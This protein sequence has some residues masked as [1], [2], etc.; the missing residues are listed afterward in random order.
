ME[1]IKKVAKFL[2]IETKDLHNFYKISAIKTFQNDE[3]IF[4][5][6]EKAKSLMFL[7][8]GYMGAYHID[9]NYKSTFF[10][11]FKADKFVGEAFALR[12]TTYP[13]NI[14]SFGTSKAVFIDYKKFKNLFFT[15]NAVLQ[16]II[17]SI[18]FKLDNYFQFANREKHNSI[19]GK[20]CLF[21]FKYEEL[22]GLIKNKETAFVLNI[23]P[24]I[25]SRYLKRLK[26]NNILET[27]GS[28]WRVINKDKLKDFIKEMEA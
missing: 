10:H 20:I 27:N 8:S 16:N 17:L 12:E 6:G 26:E 9:D 23:S 3:I 15:N 14:K 11:V 13:V 2:N 25:L 5:Q 19:F 1:D 4:Y 7:L 18:A 22:F 21:I 24:Q 28:Y